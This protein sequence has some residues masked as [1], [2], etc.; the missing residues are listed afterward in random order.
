MSYEENF[1][2]DDKKVYLKIL[3]SFNYNIVDP[4]EKFSN[5]SKPSI[6]SEN[7]KD[8]SGD[9]KKEK[10]NNETKDKYNDDEQIEEINNI[11]ENIIN[12]NLNLRYMFENSIHSK[13]MRLKT[14]TSISKKKII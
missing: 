13:D 14:I 2:I 3:E 7:E 4:V 12:K 1:N 10:E 9:E 11:H 5:I 6:D 8:I